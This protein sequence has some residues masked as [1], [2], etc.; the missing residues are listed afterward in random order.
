MIF[1]ERTHAPAQPGRHGDLEAALVAVQDLGWQHVGE[2]LLEQVF[3]LEAVQLV[4][5]GQA[6]HIFG[7]ILVQEGRAHFQRV[8]HGAAVHL[9]QDVVQHELAGIDVE[10]PCQGRGTGGPVL[11]L[12]PRGR[13]EVLA[14]QEV[15]VGTGQQLGLHLGREGGEQGLHPFPG[16]GVGAAQKGLHRQTGIDVSG[17]S[18]QEPGQGLDDAAAQDA[19]DGVVPFGDLEGDV[20]LV[21]GP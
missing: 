7:K 11:E 2:G 12:L 6:G 20:V 14:A 17:R 18:G 5:D 19:G 3:A 15:V 13:E 16:R 10:G 4:P 8:E 21:P 1:H 9:D